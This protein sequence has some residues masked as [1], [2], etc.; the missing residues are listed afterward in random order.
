MEIKQVGVVG[1]GFM[2]SRIAQLFAKNGFT[3][4]ASDLN[5]SLLKKSLNA[6]NNRLKKD[7]EKGKITANKKEKA[8]GQVR[9]TVNLKDLAECDL[10][11]EAVFEN[12][13]I[14]KQ[15]F[16][17]LDKVC[18]PE[19]ILASNTS[20]LNITEIAGV[21]KNPSRVIGTH[22]FAPVQTSTLVEVV[23]G[24][25]TSSEVLKTILAIVRKLGKEPLV[26]KDFS[27]GLLANRAFTAM[28]LEEVQM[29]WER[30]ASPEDIDKA[31]C[32]GYREPIG[33]LKLFDVLGIWQILAISEADKMKEVGSEK[34]RLHP[35]IKMMMR[36]GYTGGE[37]KKG[38]YDFYK[39]H[40]KD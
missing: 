9:G 32:L 37:G 14:K 12:M 29:V 34:G 18:S 21:T 28:V 4:V 27:F 40:M 1:C 24:T 38:I 11:I 35:L 20:Q 22:F 7:I 8:V 25:L 3:V 31:L 2:G 10:V 36:A 33:P 39:D 17:D 23:E 26:C 30:V 6:I 16:S 5:D 13:D 15:V 19:T